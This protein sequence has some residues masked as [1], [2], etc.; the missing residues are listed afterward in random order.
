MSEV[1]TL[2]RRLVLA[3]R[4]GNQPAA[5]RQVPHTA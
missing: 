1:S 2:A 5:R 3:D 4:Y